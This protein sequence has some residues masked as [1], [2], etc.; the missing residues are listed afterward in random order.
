[1]RIVKDL[2][3][4]LVL[5]VATVALLCYGVVIHHPAEASLEISAVPWGILVPG[6]VFFALVATGS[7]IVNSLYTVFGYPGPGRVLEATIKYG[8]WFSLATIVPAWILI[9]VD[10]THPTNMLWMALGFQPASRIAWMG[11]LYVVFALT[12]VAELAYM[13]RSEV[14]ERL[15]AM[16]G[17]E[18]G[19][20]IAVLV[21]TIAVHSNLGQVFGTVVAVP[22][23]FGSH[24]AAY[25][26]VSAVL[27]GAAGQSLFIASVKALR[28]ELE[29]F[30]ENYSQLL[31]RIYLVAIPALAFFMVWTTATAWYY[32]EAWSF[33][34]ELAAG[35]HAPLFWGFEVLLGIVVPLAAAIAAVKRGS[36]LAALV[37]AV[38][39]LIAGFAAKY[40]LIVL[41]QLA[42]LEH[43]GYATLLGAGYMVAHYAPTTSEVVLL[44]AGFL[45]WPTL[46]LA[47]VKL[48]PLAPG[49]KPKHLLIFK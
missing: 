36:L 25:F 43:S 24:L 9:V 42:R 47:G 37:A 26:I 41:G 30:A 29:G 48:L 45:A 31:G 7:S 15:K 33:Y 1:V 22:G 13:I 11:L 39:L 38:A 40:D 5:A 8:V 21:A 4:L 19:I 46:L 27:I 20:A 32:G 23:W 14:S 35:K 3:A 44:L 28:R 6:Y 16:R 2:I 12:L 17:L 49:E 18:L 34:S 10:L